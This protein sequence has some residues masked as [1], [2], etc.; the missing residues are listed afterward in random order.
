M[1]R[2]R[3]EDVRFEIERTNEAWDMLADTPISLRGV[4]DVRQACVLAERGGVVD[5]ESLHGIGRALQVMREARKPLE[6]RRES[7]AKLWLLGSRLAVESRL[8]DTLLASLDADGVV[9]SEA[10]PALAAA[11]SRKNT[12]GQKILE[13]LQSY[14]SG[15]TRELLSDPIYTT[16]NG[17]YV[18][19]LKAENK[20]K[21]KG[22]VHDAS[23]SGQTVYVEPED[24][25]KLA[26]DQRAAEAEERAEEER[27]LRRLSEQVGKSAA[28]I[29]DGV[30]AAQE[31]DLVIGKVRHG[32]ASGGCVPIAESGAWIKLID[33]RHPLLDRKKAIPLSLELGRDTDGL[34]ITGP[35]T[36]GKTIS[37]KTVGLCAVMAQA[38]LMP[39]A[40]EVRIGCFTQFWADIGDEQSLHQSLSTF[41]GHI[42]NIAEALGQIQPDSLVL[43]DEIGAGTDPQEGAAL[44]RALLLEFQK[45]GAKIMAS[46]HYGELKLFAANEPRFLNASMEFDQKSLGPTYRL[47]VGTPG[48][49]HAMRIA[50]RYGIPSDVIAEAESGFSIQERDIALMI[51]NLEE[52]QK[53]AREAQSRADRLATQVERAEAE[54]VRKIE[55]ADESRRRVR[56]QAAEELQEILRQIRMEAVEVF[57]AVKR[58]PSQKGIEEAR[59][60]LKSLQEVGQEFVREIKPVEK[61]KPKAHVG[62]LEKGMQ[63]RVQGFDQVGTLV[64][65]AKGDKVMVQVGAMKL[66][67]KTSQLTVMADKPVAKPKKTT[68][69]S[70]EKAQTAGTEITLRQMRAEEA[71][72][73]LEKFIDDAVLGGMPWVRIV[74]GKGEGILRKISH[75]IL[76][77]HPNVKS[78]RDGEPGEGGDGVTVAKLG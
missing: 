17:R 70:F 46:T 52:S 76:R 2:L 63:V 10:S 74:H 55:Q 13:R 25:L 7:W 59:K 49:S 51:Q 41:S 20:G 72:D 19:P 35:N 45:K 36:G 38:G 67:V 58:D 15:R 71:I 66:Q 64:E 65:D 26:N 69:I 16:R 4:R 43:L 77:R 12:L 57:E 32:T 78:F 22:I 6:S 56:E 14:L 31:L 60:K 62:K 54:A 28:M 1:P 3:P 73:R 42:K 8:E 11:R 47:L 24:V 34:L 33:A 9:R 21:I 44:A 30:E 29:R 5:G 23:A 75:D 48:S 18:L 61:V 39:P 68:Q 37:I 50:E 53:R 27:V 40:R